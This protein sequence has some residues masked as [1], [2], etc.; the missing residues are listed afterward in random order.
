MLNWQA[1][2][3]Y[4][5]PDAPPLDCPIMLELFSVQEINAPDGRLGD[6]Y[7]AWQKPMEL[8]NQLVRHSTKEGDRVIDP[9]ACTGTFLLSAA[10]MGRIASGCDI[11][12]EN[13]KIALERGCVNECAG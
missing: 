3:Y 6:R 4:Q 11:S 12:S 1:I 5:M 9:F 2:L 13:I 10:S 7:H 8:A